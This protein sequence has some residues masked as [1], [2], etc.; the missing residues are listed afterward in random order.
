MLLS[1]SISSIVFVPVASPYVSTRAMEAIANG[2]CAKAKMINAD[3]V[4]T[5]IFF[6]IVLLLVIVY[7]IFQFFFVL[8]IC[9]LADAYKLDCVFI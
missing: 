1:M 8:V 2:L 5:A 3:A 9:V 4:M 6:F 7:L